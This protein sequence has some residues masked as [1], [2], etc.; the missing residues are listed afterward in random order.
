[1]SKRMRIFKVDKRIKEGVLIHID[2][3]NEVAN[4]VLA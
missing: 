3:M 1:M 2:D 4:V